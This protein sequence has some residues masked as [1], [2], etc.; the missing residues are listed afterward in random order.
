VWVG[1]PHAAAE[2]LK[3]SH[4]EIKAR[5]LYTHP[6]SPPTAVLAEYLQS[7]QNHE[8]ALIRRV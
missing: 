5:G 2:M 1:L 4:P 6:V 8:A 7:G 3:Q